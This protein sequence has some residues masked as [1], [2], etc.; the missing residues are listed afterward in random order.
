MLG[1]GRQQSHDV[2]SNDLEVNPQLAPEIRRRTAGPLPGVVWEPLRAIARRFDPSC[3]ADF[4]VNHQSI[5]MAWPTRFR[6]SGLPIVS[7]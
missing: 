3:I 7:R 5:T 6:H 2:I 4:R 1:T